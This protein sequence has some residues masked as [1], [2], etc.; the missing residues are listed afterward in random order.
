MIMTTEELSARYDMGEK[1]L[2]SDDEKEQ[3]HGV[4]IIGELAIEGYMPAQTELGYLY[5]NGWYVPKNSQKALNW[6]QKASEQGDIEAIVGAGLVYSDMDE[7]EKAFILIKEAAEKGSAT[8][9]RLLGEIYEDGIGVT[10]DSYEAVIW[11]RKAV[12]QG[13]VAA[14]YFLGSI[15]LHDNNIEEGLRLTEE[16]AE[17]GNKN[18]QDDMGD[19][20]HYGTYSDKNLDKALYFYDKAAS[21]GVANSQTEIGIMLQNGEGIEKDE[22]AAINYF[23]GAVEQGNTIAKVYLGLAYL[24]GQGT[25][26]DEDKGWN[27]LTQ[28]ADDGDVISMVVC[29]RQAYALADS[30][31]YDEA[32]TRNYLEMAGSYFSEAAKQKN[33]EAQWRLGWMY[34]RGE[35][36]NQDKQVG[37]ELFRKAVNQDFSPAMVA[38]GICYEEGIGVPKDKSTAISYYKKAAMQ[39]D[40][41]AIDALKRLNAI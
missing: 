22:A 8:G 12:Q 11:Y 4:E 15:Y 32:E 30:G 20:Y 36:F 29:G 41:E 33:A 9:Q 13:D 26:I 28:A 19:Y 34:I 17:A 38:L 40:E 35:Y 3:R 6:F 18:A 5:R 7:D 37:I 21:Q 23:K 25:D 31:Q 14:K 27:L 2:S 16:A 1:Y 24:D 10:A 39:N